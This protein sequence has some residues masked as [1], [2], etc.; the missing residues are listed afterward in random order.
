MPVTHSTLCD[1]LRTRYV[2]NCVC[3]Y[4][5]MSDAPWGPSEYLKVGRRNRKLVRTRVSDNG[6]KLRVY[7]VRQNWK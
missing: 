7:A 4:V 2:A 5:D 3:A 1:S 6:S